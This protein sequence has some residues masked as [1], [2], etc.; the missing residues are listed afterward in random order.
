MNNLNVIN[1][2]AHTL[3]DSELTEAINIL[4]EARKERQAGTLLNMK[5]TLRPGDTVEFYVSNRG[6]YVR[7]T[8]ERTKT[9]K[10]IVIEES[11]GM[12]WDVPMG[13]LKKC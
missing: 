6:C 3:D 11:S 10:A 13:M 12:G 1:T 9:K 7:G 8:V 4:V 5:N 2:L